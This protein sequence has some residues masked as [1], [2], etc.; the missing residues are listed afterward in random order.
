MGSSSW[1]RWAQGVDETDAL[2]KKAQSMLPDLNLVLEQLRSGD[3]GGHLLLQKSWLMGWTI[4]RLRFWRSKSWRCAFRPISVQWDG[5]RDFKWFYHVRHTDLDHWTWGI[6]RDCPAVIG[7]SESE[8]ERY[9]A[10]FVR[11]KDPDGPE[12][13]KARFG[14]SRPCLGLGLFFWQRW[15]NSTCSTGT[16]STD[17]WFHCRVILAKALKK[18]NYAAVIPGAIVGCSTRQGHCDIL[19]LS[20]LFNV[21][22]MAHHIFIVYPLVN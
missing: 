19:L 15:R 18:G 10:S 22:T 17:G 16:T 11:F 3:G 1:A 5:W 9:G 21:L 12:M 13:H 8:I 2:K 6:S 20:H 7:L 14:A 4:L